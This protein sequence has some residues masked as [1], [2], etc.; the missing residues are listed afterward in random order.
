MCHV[1][2]FA[3]YFPPPSPSPNQCWYSTALN[4]S[5]TNNIEVGGE[6]GFRQRNILP[7]KCSK[8]WFFRKSLNIFGPECIFTFCAKNA[9]TVGRTCPFHFKITAYF[10]VLQLMWNLYYESIV[11]TSWK[12]EKIWRNKECHKNV[13]SA[14]T[15]TLIW[16]NKTLKYIISKYKMPLKYKI[17]EETKDSTGTRMKINDILAKKHHFR[18]RSSLTSG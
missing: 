3:A 4:T 1:F 7:R 16:C 12:N 9:I 8:T 15:K 6:G 2:H 11:H 5:R 14:M 17:R 10:Q 13:T 18:F